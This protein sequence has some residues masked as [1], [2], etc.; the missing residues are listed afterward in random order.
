MP[1]PATQPLFLNFELEAN[2]I[3]EHLKGEYSGLQIGRAS[4]ALVE[5]LM[6]EAY[7]QKQ[8]LKGLAQVVIPDARSIRI[9]PWDRGTLSA[10]EK[11]IQLS[12]L[13]LTPNNDGVAVHINIPPL[14]EERRKDL[15]K[16]V[17]RMGEDAKISVRSARQEVHSKLREMEQN[18]QISE[19]DNR[20][21]QKDL[22]LKVDKLNEEIEIMMKRKEE[23]VMTL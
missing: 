9:Q 1:S 14:T 11:A 16:V 20:G 21:A 3:M 23:D 17:R 2:K 4:S 7:G 6:V 18:K 8:S 5:N 15:S 10:I 22:Q 13:H 19:D 12:D